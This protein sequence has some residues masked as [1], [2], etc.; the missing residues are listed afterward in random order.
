M[1]DWR[2]TAPWRDTTQWWGDPRLAYAAGM[3]DG[4]T[5][6]YEAGY[7]L[8]FFKAVAG[9]DPVAIVEQLST[10][11]VHMAHDE[12]RGGP[13]PWEGRLDIVPDAVKAYG[14][15][16]RRRNAATNERNGVTQ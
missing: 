11:D 7:K 15:R 5:Q 3:C 6:G 9:A 14:A 13:V 12:Y 2:D 10:M 4:Y 8:G 1:A 16:M